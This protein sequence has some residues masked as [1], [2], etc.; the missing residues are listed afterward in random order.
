MIKIR[1]GQTRGHSRHEWLDSYHTFSFADYHDPTHMGFGHLRVIN[2]DRV[3]P[4]A[5][6]PTHG[7][8]DMEIISYPV[9]GALEHRD[10]MGNGTVIHVGDVQ[11]MSAGTGVRHSEFNP[12]ADVPVHFLQIWILPRENGLP[13]SY[14]QRH[15]PPQELDRRLCLVASGDGRDDSLLVHQDVALYAAR[16]HDGDS[17]RHSLAPGRRAYLQVVRGSVRAGGEPLSAGDGAEVTGERELVLES[18][19]GAEVLLFDLA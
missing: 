9:A 16:L 15:F 17:V 13:P 18:T 14:E 11:R 10:S 1:S 7:H 3:Q 5:G 12:S 6:F 8:R 19:G 2:E 4:S